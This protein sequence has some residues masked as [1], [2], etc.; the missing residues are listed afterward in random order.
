MKDCDIVIAAMIQATFPVL[1]KEMEKQDI[2]KPVLT[3]YVNVSKTL[4][5]ANAEHVQKLMKTE[6]AP[7]GLSEADDHLV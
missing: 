1:I 3:T 2:M 4:T 6:G 7:V 5:D